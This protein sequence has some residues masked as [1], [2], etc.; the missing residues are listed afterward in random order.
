MTK[1]APLFGQIDQIGYVVDDLDSAVAR[2]TAGTG[3]GPWTIFRNS[4]LRGR[5]RDA[6]TIVDIDVAL[7]YQGDTQIEL[8]EVL[9]ETPS[10]YDADGT[11]LTGIHHIAWIVGDLDSALAAA[12]SRGLTIAFEAD[13]GAVRV[14]YFDAGD[15]S[16]TLY[17]LIEGAGMRAMKDA[18]VAATRAWDGREAVTEIDLAAA[19]A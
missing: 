9:S 17:E 3:I 19:E 11:S 4:R 10:P 5:Y 7:G 12:L 15:G 14:V 16:G 1:P 8:I 6:P 2:W 13:S 18:G